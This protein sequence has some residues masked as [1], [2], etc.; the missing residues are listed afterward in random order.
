MN[1]RMRAILH[2]R[3][4]IL[5]VNQSELATIAGA[6]QATVS[7]W[8]SGELS[9]DLTQLGAI[10]D[11]VKKRGHEWDDAWF[12]EPPAQPEPVSEKAA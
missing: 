8:E 6:T 7:R 4:S 3:K 9:P 11:E 2:I 12:F 10:R 1:V 5:D